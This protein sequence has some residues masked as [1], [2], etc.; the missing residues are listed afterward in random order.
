MSRR[1]Y[2]VSAV[3]LLSVIPWIYGQAASDNATERTVSVQQAQSI[4]RGVVKDAKGEPIVAASVRIK[5]TTQ[6]A[7]TDLDGRFMIPNVR[8]GATLEVRSLGYVSRTVTF[9]GK[10]LSIVLNEDTKLLD[11]VIVIGYGVQKKVN[12]SGAVAA[13]D[14]KQLQARPIQN[15]TNGLQG[16]VPGLTITGTNGAPGLDNGSL[17]IRGIGTLNA[18]SPY[19]LIDGV[20]SGT[21]NAIDPSDIE[22]ISVLKDASSAAIYGSKAANGVILITTKRG[23]SGKAQV[24][25]SGYVGMQ[26]ATNLI[27]RMSSG[28]YAEL[29][30]Q[31]EKAAGRKPRFSDED[32]AKFK[33]GNDPKYPNTDWYGLAFKTGIQHRHNVNISGGTDMVKYMASIGYLNQTGILPNAARQQFN[34]R[35][36]L[37]IKLNKRLLAK[38]SLAY[39]KN[40][41]SDA[42]SAYAGGSNDQI[43]RQLNIIAPWIPNLRSDGKGYGTVSDGNPIAWL[44]HGLKVWR[45]NNNF[46][47]TAALEY[48]VFDDLKLS[49]NASYVNNIQHFNYF[50]KFIQ[51]NPNKSTDPNELHDRY[52]AWD[53][54]S[55]DLLANYK[56]SF[57]EHNLTGLLGWHLEDYNQHSLRAL[58]KSFPNNELTDLDAGDAST[59]TNGGNTRRLAMISYFGRINYDYAGKYLFEA[60]LRADAS[61]RF[62]DGHRWGY[63]PSFSA[64]WRINRESFLEDVKWL[65][66]LKL[67]ASWGILGNQDALDDYYPAINT[68]AINAG[69]PIGGS[70]QTGYYQSSYKLQAITWEKT[71]TTGFGI[72][73][74]LLKSRLTGSIDIYGRKTTDMLMNVDVPREFALGAYRDNVG[75]VANKGIEVSLGYRDNWGDWSFGAS[76]NF[77]YNKNE[78]T[79]LG[80]DVKYLG[81]GA[82]RNAV[83]QAMNTYFIY[84]AD[85]LFQ[86]NEEAAEFT[87]KYGNPF[88]RQFKAGDIRYVDTNGDGKLNGDDRVYEGSLI[89]VYTFGLNLNAGYKGFDF[90][91]MF[92]GAADVYR[93]FSG[94]VYGRFDGD[95]G[96]P[97]TL[98]RE[99]WSE[100]NKS[101]TMPRLHLTTDS[102]SSPDRV[103]S[104]F[105]LQDT[106]YIRLKNL[107]LGYTLPKDMVGRLG[108]GSIRVYYSAE[109]LFTLDRMRLNVDPEATSARLSSY[110]LLRTHSIGLNVS[111]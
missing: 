80:G 100:T 8:S 86:S 92:N 43:I 58:R 4:C 40:K 90:S 75:S 64:A 110:P 9:S 84:K 91:M 42:S 71:T 55:V 34:G 5:G 22:S 35:A 82:I 6:G 76:V 20:E 12:L 109:N 66:D 73:F 14:K 72:D 28:E 23:R 107:Q 85:G 77:A 50:Q 62:A 32:I 47:G 56:K 59:Q 104:T 11:D 1:L 27:E 7:Y 21:L 68:Y 88:G 102:P 108:L 49:A 81:N 97:S 52:Y 63:F 78:I 74:A 106:S 38:M 54:L 111:F 19:I 95:T 89:P 10:E 16:L 26:N 96:H 13:V 31:L 46:T 45:D 29:Y 57:G 18:S 44:D 51:Y 3:L 24:S 87:K 94:E 48:D 67:R 98:W 83:G 70:L 41:Y 33:A 2:K 65:S 37:D 15:L 39:I 79:N 61:S 60:N 105:W 36:N 17:Q 101:G 93:M 69:Y 99:A 30:S 25:Y 53:R 103:A